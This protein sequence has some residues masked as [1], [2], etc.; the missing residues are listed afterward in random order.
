MS[1]RRAGRRR[2]Q[3]NSWNVR[4]LYRERN[5]KALLPRKVKL[6]AKERDEA[7]SR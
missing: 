2:G 7:S 1:T 5:W 6:V 4:L 3:R